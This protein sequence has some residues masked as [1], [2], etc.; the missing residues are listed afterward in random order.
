MDFSN[1]NNL[2]IVDNQLNGYLGTGQELVIPNGV[3]SVNYDTFRRSVKDRSS[4][5][6]VV[7][8]KTLKSIPDLLFSNK[9]IDELV[10]ERGVEH[11]GAGAFHTSY[12]EK[13]VVPSTVK[14]I[15]EG[16]FCYCNLKEVVLH[17]GIQEL[18][19]HSFGGNPLSLFIFP[20]SLSIMNLDAL[21]PGPLLGS[22]TDTDVVCYFNQ[23]DKIKCEEELNCNL[24]VIVDDDFNF[25]KAY[26]FLENIKNKQHNANIRKITLIGY[27]NTFYFMMLKQVSK[28]LGVEIEIEMVE[29]MDEDLKERI[30]KSRDQS[31]EKE[32]PFF[33]SGDQE[34]DDLVNEIKEKSDILEENLRQDILSQVEHLIEQYQKDLEGLRPKLDI[35]EKAMVTL[36]NAQTPKAL[37]L[38]LIS[39]LQK[40]NMNFIDLDQNIYLKQKIEKYKEMVED[41]STFEK[42]EQVETMEDKIQEM[43]YYASAMGLSHIH[44]EILNIFTEIE[45]S[46]LASSQNSLVFNENITTPE[47]ELTRRVDQLYQKLRDAYIFYQSLRGENTTSL[48]NDMKDLNTIINFLD[49]ESK[50]DYQERLDGIQNKYMEEVKSLK[51]DSDSELEVRKELVPILEGLSE[52]VPDMK[53][54]KGIL[55]DIS[56]A[57]RIIAGES[58]NILG[59]ITSTTKDIMSLLADDTLDKKTKKTVKKSLLQILDNS[60]DQIINHT[61]QIEENENSVGE[62]LDWSSKATLQV[63]SEM[64]GIQNFIEE[65]IDYNQ[66]VGNLTSGFGK[67]A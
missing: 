12:L 62:N 55:D 61:F 25:G 64:Q 48:G 3:K 57:K 63:L 53:E 6:K 44:S 28:F 7:I 39:R 42:K 67:G 16:A 56:E 36:K 65:S 41:D 38:E 17:E 15:D 37:R 66:E 10:L 27:N 1:H 34:I 58:E 43:K 22:R 50:K 23:I 29:E 30:A 14:C 18:G 46:L 24:S 35:E 19:D 4:F 9:T 21:N 52:L 33:H 13:L 26:T 11:I 51:I 40:I 20:E 47:Q 32:E 31:L 45:N 60:Y 8:P 2:V 59:A 54:K 49:T 5:K